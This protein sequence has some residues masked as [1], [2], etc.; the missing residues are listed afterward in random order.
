LAGCLA[1]MRGKEGKALA[2]LI[3]DPEGRPGQPPHAARESALVG[4]CDASRLCKYHNCICKSHMK[5]SC[6]LTNQNKYVIDYYS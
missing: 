6:T 5:K 3:K 1:R 4:W 2:A